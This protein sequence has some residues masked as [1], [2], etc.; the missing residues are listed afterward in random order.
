MILS[1]TAFSN[2][3][4]E[5]G[6][7]DIDYGYITGRKFRRKINLPS[8]TEAESIE[9]ALRLLS[10]TGKMEGVAGCCDKPG[11]REF[12]LYLLDTDSEYLC[13]GN[14][15]QMCIRYRRILPSADPKDESFV[16]EAVNLARESVSYRV[17]G[18]CSVFCKSDCTHALNKGIPAQGYCRIV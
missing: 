16:D 2:T 7:S 5:L 4:M 12:V 15:E 10:S 14:R 17:S 11:S 9:S 18:R 6:S 8:I 1:S 13:C 3:I